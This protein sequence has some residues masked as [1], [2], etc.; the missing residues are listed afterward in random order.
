MRSLGCGNEV[1]LLNVMSVVPYLWVAC[2]GRFDQAEK[3]IPLEMSPSR[4]GRER[5]ILNRAQKNALYKDPHLHPLRGRE[6][7]RNAGQ[8][9]SLHREEAESYAVRLVGG[10][11]IGGGP[12]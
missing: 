5:R 4:E 10:T 7:G 11:S 9:V 6:R 2:L 12:P 3:F 1:C 8:V